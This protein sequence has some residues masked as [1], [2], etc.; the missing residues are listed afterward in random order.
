MKSEKSISER[1]AN[2]N[3]HVA[4]LGAMLKNEGETKTYKRLKKEEDEEDR[5]LMKDYQELGK[6]ADK[7]HNIDRRN[8]SHFL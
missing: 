6:G 3:K 7:A 8:T 5:E 4:E 2:H 1:N